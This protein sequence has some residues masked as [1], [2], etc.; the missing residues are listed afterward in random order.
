MKEKRKRVQQV[1]NCEPRGSNF[2]FVAGSSSDA[3]M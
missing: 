1:I 2:I 3:A